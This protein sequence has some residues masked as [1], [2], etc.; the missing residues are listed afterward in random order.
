MRVSQG[1]RSG[2]TIF[3]NNGAPRSALFGCLGLTKNP[4]QP[5]R[6]HTLDTLRD[7]G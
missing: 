2:I 7:L 6:I 1:A 4:E 5:H 3:I